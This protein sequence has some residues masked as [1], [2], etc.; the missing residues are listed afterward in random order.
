V[1]T[2]YKSYERER[3]RILAP[4][5]GY[6]REMSEVQSGKKVGVIMSKALLI[7]AWSMCRPRT[8]KAGETMSR[9][10][11]GELQADMRKAR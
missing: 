3:A 4:I 7:E 6:R 9:V 10:N 2:V 5:E 11:I 8:N 1:F